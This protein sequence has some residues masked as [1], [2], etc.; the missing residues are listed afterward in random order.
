MNPQNNNQP[1]GGERVSLNYA[2]DK[3]SFDYTVGDMG[4]GEGIE[5]QY[6]VEIGEVP[7]DGTTYYNDASIT[8][9][10]IS[11]GTHHR[12]NIER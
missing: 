1:A 9:D 12:E 7:Q 10:S 11:M 8:G 5:L 3:R 4:L 6:F 2:S